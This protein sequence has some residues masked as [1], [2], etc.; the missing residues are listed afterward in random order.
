MISKWAFGPIKYSRYT[1][2]AGSFCWK[3]CS[4][5][6]N[7][8][9]YGLFWT[10]VKIIV[11][12]TYLYVYLFLL[13]FHFVHFFK[14]PGSIP[15]TEAFCAQVRWRRMQVYW[16]RKVSS[17]FACYQFIDRS[18]HVTHLSDQQYTL[19]VMSYCV[20]GGILIV[21]IGYIDPYI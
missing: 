12:G 7:L 17:V 8:S 5:S 13:I 3:F 1:W 4:H 18:L 15:S 2:F 9:L 10:C 16:D 14:T 6:V 19:S 11:M 21:N 20:N